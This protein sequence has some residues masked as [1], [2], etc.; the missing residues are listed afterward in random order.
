LPKASCKSEGRDRLRKPD[1]LRGSDRRGA[2]S[3]NVRKVLR[4]H[5][6]STVCS[7]AL[8][9][10]RGHCYGRGTATFLI[11]GRICTRSCLYCGIEKAPARPDPLNPAEP[12]SL[13]AAVSELGLEYVVI[14]SV[15]RD[16]LRDGG[17][18]HFAETVRTLRREIPGIRIELLT[19]DFGGNMD[20]LEVVANSSPDIFNHNL[21][22]VRNLFPVMRPVASYGLSVGILQRFA[23][24]APEIPTK[25]GMML[26]LGESREDVENA[27]HDLRMAGVSILTLGQY[28]QPSKE[29]CPVARYVPPAEFEALRRHALEMG[30]S[31]VASGPLVRSSFH[32]DLISTLHG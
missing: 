31:S 27:L 1:W 12:S 17:A 24:L 18:S 4:R 7:E 8:C 28:L 26:G 10:N 9:P 16:D 23:S 22:T 29:N 30:F 14:T 15:T 2:G 5:G 21:E 3:A 11:M 13:A 32:A 25:S 6:L 19:P 20:A